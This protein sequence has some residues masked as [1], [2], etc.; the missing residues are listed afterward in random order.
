LIRS[1]L[2]TGTLRHR[3][4]HPRAH[5]FGYRVFMPYL[6]LDELPALLDGI[7]GWSARGPAIGW[8]RRADFLGDPAQPLKEEVRRR[9]REETGAE[10]RGPVFLLANLR[11]F[12]VQMNPLCCYYCFSEDGSRLEHLVAEVTNTPWGERHSY[13]LS[14]GAGGD[15]DREAPASDGDTPRL[16]CDFDKAFH[17][18]P[19]NPMGM[20][21]HWRSNV[22]G[23]ALGIHLANHTEAQGKVFDATLSLRAQPRSGRSLNRMLA[24]YPLMTA[25]VA[26][27]IYWQALRLFLKRIPFYPHPD[28]SPSGV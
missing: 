17:V 13:V 7:P 26:V 1:R 10:H 2:Y 6:D 23:D 28:R 15:G 25:Q 24:L 22:P 3:R 16:D 21:Y 14:H 12:G 5:S 4:F 18:S 27:G 19:F 8:F 20:R 9:V 11:Y